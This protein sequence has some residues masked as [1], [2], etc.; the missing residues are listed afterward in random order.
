MTTTTFPIRRAWSATCPDGR[1]RDHFANAVAHRI[2]EESHESA[3]AGYP[4]ELVDDFVERCDSIFAKHGPEDYEAA[5]KLAAEIDT[6]ELYDLCG[7][8][9]L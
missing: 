8:A 4:P 2:T 3:M 5:A 1:I 7:E 9:G 6:A